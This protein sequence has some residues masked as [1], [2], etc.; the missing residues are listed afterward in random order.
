MALSDITQGDSPTYQL[1]LLDSSG[2]PPSGGT[3]SWTV[4]HCLKADDDDTTELIQK[5]NQ[6]VGEIDASSPNPD[7]NKWDIK[8]LAADTAAL[9]PGVYVWI[10]KVVTDANK[11]LTVKREQVTVLAEGCS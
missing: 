1:T 4:L 11:T 3:L 5:S 9:S 10:V 6:V 8:Y 7:S 2:I